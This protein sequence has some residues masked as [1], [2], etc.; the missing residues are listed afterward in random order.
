MSKSF[1][2]FTDKRI[3]PEEFAEL[4]DSVGWGSI[5]EYDSHEI[6]DSIESYTFIAHIRD[7][8]GL[9]VGYVSTFS[10]RAFSTFIGELV[11]RPEFQG[12]GLGKELL[13]AVESRFEGVPV[14]ANPFESAKDFFIRQEYSE[15]KRPMVVVSKRNQT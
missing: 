10:D 12:R 7:E 4:M 5:E 3:E 13:R 14:Y 8:M 15:P 11:V 9:L 1:Q 2:V 6:R